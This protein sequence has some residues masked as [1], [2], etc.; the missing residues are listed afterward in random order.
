MEKAGNRQKLNSYFC[1]NERV[2]ELGEMEENKL[3]MNE[4]NSEGLS[5]TPKNA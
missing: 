3:K 4:G 1:L 5:S 2:F